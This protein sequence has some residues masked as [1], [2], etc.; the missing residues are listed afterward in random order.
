MGKFTERASHVSSAIDK[1]EE[2]G[3]ENFEYFLPIVSN[4]SIPQEFD[5]AV[6][7]VSDEISSRPDRSPIE[8]VNK[9]TVRRLLGIECRSLNEARYVLALGR[10]VALTKKSQSAVQTEQQAMLRREAEE[11]LGI[12]LILV[13]E[14]IHAKEGKLQKL[15][16]R[17][18]KTGGGLIDFQT[19]SCKWKSAC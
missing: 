14:A 1:A 11:M 18:R 7:N 10:A 9:E 15:S 12:T 19:Y 13:S 2:V 4:S 17:I 5:Y 6:K 8:F 16:A 3:R